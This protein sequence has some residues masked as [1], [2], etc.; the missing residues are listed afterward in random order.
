MDHLI[1]SLSYE[2]MQNAVLAGV[3]AS[4]LCGIIGTFVV[5]KRLVFISGGIAHAAFGGMGVCFL[6][7]VNPTIGAIV[8]S[9]ACA[10]VL[11]QMNNEQTRSR[12]ATIG[13]L[14]AVGMAVGI[15]CLHKTPGYAP[16]LM[17]YL[18]GNILLVGSDQL[19]VS[20]LVDIVV[21]T[22]V[23]L[24]FKEFVA[25]AFDEAFA[26]IQGIP[27]RGMLTLL[28]TLIAL[29]VV[30]LIQVVGIILVIALLTIPPVT[31]LMLLRSLPGVMLLSVIIGLVMTLTGLALS[32]LYDVPPGPAIILLGAALMTIVYGVQRLA[33]SPTRIPTDH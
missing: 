32:Y 10:L 13:V 33:G 27:V 23:A 17:A 26:A 6:Y 18:F 4:I 25:V 28:L 31:S 15:V 19:M 2:F 21:L 11:G 29:S 14:W 1:N 24:F 3:L 8:S 20:L 7:G 5:V 16:D 30:M 9:V 12:D 22:I